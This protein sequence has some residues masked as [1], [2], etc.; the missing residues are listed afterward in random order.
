M[1]FAKTRCC[2]PGFMVQETTRNR[3]TLC[4]AKGQEETQFWMVRIGFY[5]FFAC[6]SEFL[7]SFNYSTM[8][9][10][11][12]DLYKLSQLPLG[13]WHRRDG[14]DRWEFMC[15]I[16]DIRGGGNCCWARTVVRLFFSR[17]CQFQGAASPVPHNVLIFD[18]NPNGSSFAI[19][20]SKC[21]SI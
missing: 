12:V 17:F 3:F 6:S 1:I 9:I 20:G 4:H 16:D 11:N 5:F 2:W 21:T 8:G 13:H 15:F 14:L 18:L 10:K 19:S 7:N